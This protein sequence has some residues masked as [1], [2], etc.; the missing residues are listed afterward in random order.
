MKYYVDILAALLTPAIAIITTYIAIQQYR[1]GKAKLRHDLYDRRMA[2][3][4]AASKYL[5]LVVIT[6]AITE[7]PEEEKKALQEFIAA[8]SESH[9]LFDKEVVNYLALIHIT[10]IM[11]PTTRYLIEKGDPA[12]VEEQKQKLA[13][14]TE[15]HR[16]QLQGL[17]DVFMK[18]LDLKNLK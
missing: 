13:E 4:K 14:T 15:T 18:Y 6:Y 12:Q 2:V 11:R 9:F 10:G 17:Q 16:Q 3:Y 8:N 7:N 5:S 1:N